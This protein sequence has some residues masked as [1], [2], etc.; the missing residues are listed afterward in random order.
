[1]HRC[2]QCLVLYPTIN[3]LT[4][5]IYQSHRMD[6]YICKC[7]YKTNRNYNY[8]RHIKVIYIV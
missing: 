8:E 4:L 1:M 3:E 2:P 6:K 7:G 5:H